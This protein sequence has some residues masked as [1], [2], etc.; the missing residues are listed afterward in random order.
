MAGKSWV[1][2]A[3]TASDRH[4]AHTAPAAT[5]ARRE[6]PHPEDRAKAIARAQAAPVP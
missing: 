2:T 5:P 1:A 4:H 3:R 6:E